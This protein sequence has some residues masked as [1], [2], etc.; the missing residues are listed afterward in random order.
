MSFVTINSVLG[1][2]STNSCVTEM[3]H[4]IL[5]SNLS[6]SVCEHNCTVTVLCDVQGV[7]ISIF[8]GFLNYGCKMLSVRFLYPK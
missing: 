7:F 1:L 3:P 5:V 4:F 8:I 6:M 2:R